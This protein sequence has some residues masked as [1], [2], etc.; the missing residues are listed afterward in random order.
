[1]PTPVADLLNSPLMTLSLSRNGLSGSRLL[2]S[3]I[4]APLP[5]ALQFLGL[6]PLPMN[7]A[8]NRF[9]GSAF[10]APCATSGSASSHGSATVTPTPRMTVRRLIGERG[11]MGS[12]PGEFGQAGDHILLLRDRRQNKKAAGFSRDPTPRPPSHRPRPRSR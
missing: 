3:S 2:L 10:S 7:S 11:G 6:I 4:S 5:L 9:G 1:M 12:S 8:A